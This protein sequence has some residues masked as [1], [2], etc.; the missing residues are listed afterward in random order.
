[1]RISLAITLLVS[2]ALAGCGGSIRPDLDV[3]VAAENSSIDQGAKSFTFAIGDTNRTHAERGARIIASA[4]EKRGWTEKRTGADLTIRVEY[5]ISEPTVLREIVSTSVFKP[6]VSS[7]PLAGTPSQQYVGEQLSCQVSTLHEKKLRIAARA[8]D[9]AGASD[10]WSVTVRAWDVGA[11]LTRYAPLLAAVAGNYLQQTLREEIDVTVSGNG[12]KVQA[13]K[14]PKITRD[15]LYRP[16]PG[17]AKQL[18]DPC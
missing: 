4:L 2:A 3:K 7:T 1:V 12:R 6:L 13:A 14:Q 8:G 16:E 17:A 11:N 5:S 15:T 18:G 9:Q 10:E